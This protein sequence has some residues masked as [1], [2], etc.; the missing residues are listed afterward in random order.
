MPT[1]NMLAV[2]QHIGGDPLASQLALIEYVP[3]V[4]RDNY[5]RAHAATFSNEYSWCSP[6]STAC[7]ALGGPA[8]ADVYA[9][10]GAVMDSRRTS[11]R[12]LEKG[13]LVRSL[14]MRSARLHAACLS[15]S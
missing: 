13:V 10:S 9:Q 2:G 3:V 12:M 5:V 4:V 6:P 7:D 15:G 14:T 8:E 11:S 1:A